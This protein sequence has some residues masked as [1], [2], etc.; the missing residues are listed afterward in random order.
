MSRPPRRLRAYALVQG[1]TRAD[2]DLSL[3]AMVS[4]VAAGAPPGLSPEQARIIERC[5]AAPQSLV[6]L[7]AAL[8]LPIGVIRV[9]LADLLADGTLQVHGSD[10]RTVD[11]R[12]D[13][14][15]LE[16]VLDGIESL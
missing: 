8:D 2:A 3:D 10:R 5:A 9:L 12:H 4:G 6:D 14:A 13:L 15:L 16:E 7:S 1:R 11:V